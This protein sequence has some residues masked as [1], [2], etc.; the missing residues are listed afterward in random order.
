MQF[1]LSLEDQAKDSEEHEAFNVHFDPI[2]VSSSTFL[3]GLSTHVHRWFRLTPSYGPDLVRFILEK[4]NAQ[5]SDYVLDPF[6]GAGTTAIE[7]SLEGFDSIGLE[8]NPLLHFVNQVSLNWD[9]DPVSLTNQ[10]NRLLQSYDDR[11]SSLNLNDIE[12]NGFEIP[13]I[14]NPFRWWRPDVLCRMLLIK[15]LLSEISDTTERDFF[16]LALAGVLVPDL[17]NV[18]LGRLQL[19][20]IDRSNDDIDVKEIFENH[21]RTMIADLGEI[22]KLHHMGSSKVFNIDS[23]SLNEF[24]PDRKVDFVITSPPY[25]NRYSYVWNTRPHLYMLDF[26]DQAKQASDID[27]ATIGGT[28]GTATSELQKGLYEPANNAI[29]EVVFPIAEKIREHDNLMANYVVHYFNRLSVH[30]DNLSNHLSED[31]K[32]AYVVGNSWI[33]GVYIETDVLLGQIFEKLECGYNTTE[34]QRFRKRHSG[35]E[36]YE[37][38]VFAQKD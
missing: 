6:S 26:I 27:R 32:L 37:S 31:A 22:H 13:P 4:F 11:C 33:K 5:K 16:R 24:S 15:S 17:T 2:H 8:I 30:L 14:H 12:S 3:A 10:L 34:V 19:H 38:I 20:F 1:N 36:L 21:C 29:E 23:V 7:C 9:L 25:P 18:T 35:K 28:W